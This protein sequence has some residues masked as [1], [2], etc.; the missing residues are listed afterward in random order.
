MK[1]KLFFAFAAFCCA[2]LAYGTYQGLV[3][4]PTQWALYINAVVAQIGQANYA[5]ARRTVALM[6][7]R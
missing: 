3:V 4:A 6:E 1:T 2:F 7:Q 5:A